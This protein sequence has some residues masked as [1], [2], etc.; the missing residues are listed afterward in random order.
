VCGNGV[1]EKGEE[2]DDGGTMDGDGCS[3][4]CKNEVVGPTAFRIKTLSLV[5]PDI[6][7][8]ALNCAKLTGTVNNQLKASLTGDTNPKDGFYDLSPMLIFRPL[9]QDKA[10]SELDFVLGQCSITDGTCSIAGAM[11][12]SA[13]EHNKASGLC[14]AAGADHDNGGVVNAPTDD[15]FYNDAATI[16][17]S[18]QGADITLQDAQIAAVYNADPA[19][20][21]TKG[22]IRGFL[23]QADADATTLP[24][25]LPIIGGQPVS[26][27]LGGDEY[28]PGSD[29]SAGGVNQEDSYN[30][31]RGWFFYLNF[32]AATATL[33]E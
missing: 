2:C 30:G 21:L 17:I 1:V 5:D 27:L 33:T 14:L 8:N 16:H 23:S 20:G 10:S 29:S 25:T 4:D 7:A 22:L 15:C 31:Q 3:H 12:Y 24:A 32:T 11:S 26:A 9:A 6:F 28:C 19:T 13:T 18:L